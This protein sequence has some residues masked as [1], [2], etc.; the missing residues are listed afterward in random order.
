MRFASQ[1]F[2][3]PQSA[4]MLSLLGKDSGALFFGSIEL[5][6][7]CKKNVYLWICWIEKRDPIYNT[8]FELQGTLCLWRPCPQPALPRSWATTN[9]LSLTPRISMCVVC[10]LVSPKFG[11]YVFRVLCV[12]LASDCLIMGGLPG[13]LWTPNGNTVSN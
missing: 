8:W 10:F 12:F 9:H 11:K 6:V 4:L 5:N 13:L 1:T 3:V 7:K 2:A